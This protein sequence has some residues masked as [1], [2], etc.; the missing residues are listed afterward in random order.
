MIYKIF[1]SF[2]Y[3]HI[4]NAMLPKMLMYEGGV[5]SVSPDSS[6]ISFLKKKRSDPAFE[7]LAEIDETQKNYNWQFEETIR[8]K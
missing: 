3:V 7:A 8:M 5:W 2:R 4:S 1:R 6:C